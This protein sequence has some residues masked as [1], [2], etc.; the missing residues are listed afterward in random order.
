MSNEVIISILATTVCITA[1]TV[2]VLSYQM[3]KI[4]RMV[5]ELNQNP[6]PPQPN[7]YFGIQAFNERMDNFIKVLCKRNAIIDKLGD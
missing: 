2:A 1:I 5:K 4:W 3:R 7:P 6:L